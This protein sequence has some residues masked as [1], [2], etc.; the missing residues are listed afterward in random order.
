M[1][2]KNDKELKK[3]NKDIAKKRKG[4][5][6]YRLKK[7]LGRK[8]VKLIEVSNGVVITWEG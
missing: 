6:W 2:N 8:G 1:N 7:R 5:F 3:I 4:N